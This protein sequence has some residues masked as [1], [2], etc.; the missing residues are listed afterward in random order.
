MVENEVFVHAEQ[1][2]TPYML[3]SVMPRK[4]E[5][6]PK[7]YELVGK[8]QEMPHIYIVQITCNNAIIRLILFCNFNWV[9][10]LFSAPVRDV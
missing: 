10:S 7:N 4:G 8:F 9:I 1:S 3:K 2:P 5:N 6:F